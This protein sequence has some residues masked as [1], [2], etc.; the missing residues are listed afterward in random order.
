MDFCACRVTTGV[1]GLIFIIKSSSRSKVFLAREAVCSALLSAA[2]ALESAA[3]WALISLASPEDFL[4][5]VVT[6]SL[7]ASSAF[8]SGGTGAAGAVDFL[9]VLRV[10]AGTAVGVAASTGP[11][12]APSI[13]IKANVE[14]AMAE[15]NCAGA[16]TEEC[17]VMSPLS[18]DGFTA[19]FKREDVVDCVLIWDGA[20]ANADPNTAKRQTEENFMLDNWE[21]E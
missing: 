21:T 16:T 8:F 14:V 3:F 13:I 6:E 11:G 9:V 1:L 18:G 7:A 15:A 4:V 19:A 5:S 17:G 2:M 12:A 10:V 20:N